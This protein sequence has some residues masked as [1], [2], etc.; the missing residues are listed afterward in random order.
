MEGSG[1]ILIVS[2]L[3]IMAMLLATSLLLSGTVML[4]LKLP[5][6][7]FR[8]TI[9]EITYSSRS[10]LAIA[11]ADVSKRLSYKAETHLYQ[12]YTDLDDYPEAEAGGYEIL[13]KWL[14]DTLERYPALGVA[15]NISEPK[16]T[17]KW[18][19]LDGRGY[20]KAE[21]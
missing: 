9:L 13:D 17:C 18:G 5:E 2:T 19:G 20:S 14:L 3:I 6:S 12:N 1:Q 10:A 16:F 11:L 21:A 8:S 15:L 4:R 7:K